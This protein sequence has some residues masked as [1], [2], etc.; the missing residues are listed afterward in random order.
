MIT[1]LLLECNAEFVDEN[2]VRHPVHLRLRSEA[3]NRCTLVG[4]TQGASGIAPH[5]F[6]ALEGV[7]DEKRTLRSE[8]AFVSHVQPAEKKQT[9][10]IDFLVD[11]L[12]L[13]TSSLN[14]M[15][16]AKV[17][18][19][20]STDLSSTWVLSGSRF[21][22]ELLCEG[23]IAFESNGT[24]VDFRLER[25]AHT[26]LAERSGHAIEE[27]TLLPVLRFRKSSGGAEMGRCIELMN[28][29]Q[30]EVDY[31]SSCLAF[32]SQAT[33][34][35]LD[36]TRALIHDARSSQDL[37]REM[38][39]RRVSLGPPHR[40]VHVPA[41]DVRTNLSTT[42]SIAKSWGQH[43]LSAID[44]YVSSFILADESR[45][46]ALS[47]SAEAL[48][49]AY[50][51]AAGKRKLF[52]TG[53]FKKLK[54][55]VEKPIQDLLASFNK[56]ELVPKLMGEKILEMNRPSYKDVIDE[57]CKLLEVNRADLYP[58]DF[59]F[60]KMRNDM[61][62]Q[63]KV[64]DRKELAAEAQKLTTLLERLISAALKRKPAA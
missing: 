29:W 20:A 46:I 16:T 45:F 24:S 2:D 37:S 49:E 64:P 17:S 26:N 50:Q 18:L 47:T 61:V 32:Y 40:R 53:E 55:A 5:L 4:I 51:S 7:V 54:T 12:S 52:T 38:R 60:V 11:D 48:K 13:V 56:A 19:S 57:L 43:F 1:P 41:A 10:S 6:G 22:S 14:D 28:S 44:F 42:A 8:T 62:H 31:I 33:V 9:N 25:D 27:T 34:A 15:V 36:R 58:D 39:F 59:T 23:Q 63:G 3:A 35:W 30:E 21:I